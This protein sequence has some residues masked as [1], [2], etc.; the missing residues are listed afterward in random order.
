MT[1]HF[2]GLELLFSS[3]ESSIALEHLY[4]QVSDV[5]EKGGNARKLRERAMR[6]FLPKLNTHTHIELIRFVY[7]SFLQ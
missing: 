4:L 7:G 3:Q 2:V 5:Q 1:W 6:I